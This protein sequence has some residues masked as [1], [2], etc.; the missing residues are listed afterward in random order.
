M[1]AE[2]IARRIERRLE[3]SNSRQLNGSE[4]P[5][6]AGTHNAVCGGEIRSPIGFARRVVKSRS[7]CVRDG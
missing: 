4:A 6:V 5:A 2:R 1:F 7:N 3:A